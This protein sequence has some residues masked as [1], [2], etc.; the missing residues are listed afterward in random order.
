MFVTRALPGSAPLARLRAEAHA[1]VWE[2][3]RPPAPEELAARAGD[4]DGLLAMLTDRVDAAL[5]DRLPRLRA[6]V[7]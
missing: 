3:D 4:C 5:L 6:S 2:H 1:D 7:V